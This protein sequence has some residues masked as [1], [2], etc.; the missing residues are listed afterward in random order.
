LLYAAA[1]LAFVS[2][3][4]FAWI[5]HH[6]EF[7]WL[8][9][10]TGAIVACG[11]IPLLVLA[12]DSVI[13]R[14]LLAGRLE[15]CVGAPLGLIWLVAFLAVIPVSLLAIASMAIPLIA[16]RTVSIFAPYLMLLVSLGA[17]GLCQARLA[18]GLVVV[19]LLSLNTAGFIEYR[20][21][22]HSP[23]DFSGLAA[24]VAPKAQP[25]D[26]WFTF[27]HWA[28]TPI[29]YYLDPDQYTFVARDHA[30]ALSKQPCARVWVL[31]LS[32]L[33]PP[34]RVT[35]PL[36]GHRR[37]IRVEASEIY[38]DLYVPVSDDAT[39]KTKAGD[40]DIGLH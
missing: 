34:P 15:S 3:E 12:A 10:R 8:A 7:S 39:E 11:A 6:R 13:R 22:P 36:S 2:I 33:P 5:T 28:T 23:C 21:R 35:A 4:V 20:E 17:V 9:R 30:Q 27:K 32:G 40:S 31:G 1:A 29:F 24:K 38:M 18:R 26:L 16:A 14:G 25:G 37:L 19:L